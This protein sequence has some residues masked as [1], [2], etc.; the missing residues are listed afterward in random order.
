MSK[1]TPTARTELV[2]QIALFLATNYPC[3]CGAGSGCSE[4][5]EA[6]AIVEMMEAA[7]FGLVAG[8]KAEALEEAAEEFDTRS[9][10]LLRTMQNMSEMIGTYSADDI[11]RYG[12]YSA[13]AQY[14]ANRLRRLAAS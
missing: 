8:A 12:A 9:K 7:G 1:A 10:T 2:D 11:V 5:P 13:E 4:E 14:T 6:E 3:D